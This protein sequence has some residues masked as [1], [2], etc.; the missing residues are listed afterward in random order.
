M[1]IEQAKR[2]LDEHKEQRC[3]SLRTVNKALFLCGDL[4]DL[5]E[6][7]FE[8]SETPWLESAHLVESARP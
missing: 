3:H 8:V 6:S 2:I 5:D 1:N 4:R 7:L